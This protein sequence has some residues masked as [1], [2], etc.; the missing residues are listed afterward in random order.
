M[1]AYE[2][3]LKQKQEEAEYNR[4]GS[5]SKRGSSLADRILNLFGLVADDFDFKPW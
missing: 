5:L 1:A 3:E 4:K 2:N